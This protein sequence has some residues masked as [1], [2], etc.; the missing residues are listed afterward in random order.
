MRVRCQN[1]FCIV[2]AG[3]E[4]FGVTARGKYLGL[5]GVAFGI[6]GVF[7]YQNEF[8]LVFYGA[9]EHGVT[10]KKKMSGVGG[11]CESWVGIL[12]ATV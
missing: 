4:K 9:E 10:T 3:A 6:L 2:Y 5:A 11:N 7:G 8:Y 1:V 12:I